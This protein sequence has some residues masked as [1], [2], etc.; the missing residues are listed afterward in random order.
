MGNSNEM[1]II[2]DSRPENEGVGKRVTATRRLR[3]LRPHTGGSSRLKTARKK[4]RPEAVTNCINFS[5]TIKAG[6]HQNAWMEVC[7]R[8]RAIYLDIEDD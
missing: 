6:V 3:Q 1:T 2:F 8:K 5:G 7:V 4:L